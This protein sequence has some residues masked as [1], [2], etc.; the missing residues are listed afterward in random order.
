MEPQQG[1]AGFILAIFGL[2]VPFVGMAG[3]VMSIV[4]Y[5]QAN[6]EGFV[7]GSRLPVWWSALP[8]PF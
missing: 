8:E 1:V 2:V 3:L 6:R 7:G 5:R 4:G